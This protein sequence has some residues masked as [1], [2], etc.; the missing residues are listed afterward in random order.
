MSAERKAR[1]QALARVLARHRIF[2]ADHAFVQ[3]VR[4]GHYDIATDV[5]DHY[6]LRKVFDDLALTI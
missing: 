6:K 5:H 3:N 1:G 2:A 4:R